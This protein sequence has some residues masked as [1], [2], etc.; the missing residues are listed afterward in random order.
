VRIVVNGPEGNW[1][2]ASRCILADEVVRLVEWLEAAAEDLRPRRFDTLDNEFRLELLGEEPRRLRVYL[3]GTFRPPQARA[4][5]AAEFFQDYPVTER[6][7][8]QAA[9]SF[10]EQLRR[11]TKGRWC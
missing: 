2:A 4:E 6:T 3:E 10:R 1:S 11:A 5:P 9:S 8:R 7:L